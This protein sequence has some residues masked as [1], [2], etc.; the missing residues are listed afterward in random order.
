MTITICE[1]VPCH[2]CLGKSGVH[3]AII[4][5]CPIS[6]I[7]DVGLCLSSSS[8][9][10]CKNWPAFLA[11]KEACGTFHIITWCHV[12]IWFM[13][14][15][16]E[17]IQIMAHVDCGGT[18][19]VGVVWNSRDCGPSWWKGTGM[20]NLEWLQDPCSSLAWHQALLLPHRRRHLY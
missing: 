12:D 8:R 9:H 13:F 6:G 10:S 5:H 2:R 17:Q 7:D 1:Y 18:C 15:L 11:A 20:Q 14:E 19:E 16:V 4:S 3:V